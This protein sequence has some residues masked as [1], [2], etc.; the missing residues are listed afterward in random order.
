[1]HRR[2]YSK[3]IMRVNPPMGRASGPPV[4]PIGARVSRQR[5]SSPIEAANVSRTSTT[6]R[7]IWLRLHDRDDPLIFGI[8][9]GVRIAQLRGTACPYPAVPLAGR[10]PHALCPVSP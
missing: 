10:P 9:P 7:Q 5:P 1:M 2:E 4:G 8:P 3:R 6:P